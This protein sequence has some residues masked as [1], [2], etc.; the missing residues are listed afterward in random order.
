MSTDEAAEGLLRGR[1]FAPERA[2]VHME[3][4]LG[5][6][7]LRDEPDVDGVA[8]RPLRLDADELGTYRVLEEAFR[9]AWDWRRE[10]TTLERWTSELRS[11]DPLEPTAT[12]VSEVGDDRR[13]VGVLIAGDLKGTGWV[14]WLAVHRGHQRRGVG[15]T[16]LLRAFRA[17]RERGFT[18]VRVNVDAD[19]ETRAHVVYERV[20]TGRDA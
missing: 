19:N 12:L 9:D 15:A 4:E 13:P 17:F 11:G 5:A 20:G 6:S 3:V 7:A 2:Y 16:L 1:G 10:A 8:L 14:E 18:Q